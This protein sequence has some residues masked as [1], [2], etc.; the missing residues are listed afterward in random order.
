[1]R[2]HIVYIDEKTDTLAKLLDGSKRMLIYDGEAHKPPYRDVKVG[3][4]IYFIP[5]NASDK[6]HATARVRYIFNTEKL[7]ITESQLLLHSYQDAL[8]L[9]DAE[10]WE[11]AGLDCAVVVEV[12]EVQAV[13]PFP[14]KRSDLGHFDNWFVLDSAELLK[15]HAVDA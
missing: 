7:S 4:T 1:M 14:I 5:N 3:D 15:T 12:E 6:V 11:W 13:T 8:Q 2:G 10:I 9:N